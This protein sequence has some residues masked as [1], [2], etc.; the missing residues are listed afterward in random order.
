MHT[1][2][3]FGFVTYDVE[4]RSRAIRTPHTCDVPAHT[5]TRWC[6]YAGVVQYKYIRTL[7]FKHSHTHTH[8]NTHLLLYARVLQLRSRATQTYLMH[9]LHVD[10]A[11]H[12]DELVEHK[13]PELVLQVLRKVST[14]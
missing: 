14:R 9:E 12:E 10:H 3:G 1:C 8:T 11:K 13:V 4:P 7:A 6:T 5:L 2:F